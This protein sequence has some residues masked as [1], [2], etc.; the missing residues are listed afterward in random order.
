MLEPDLVVSNKR[1]LL[2]FQ[3]D[4]QEPAVVLL[5]Q[6]A[7]ERQ[8]IIPIRHETHGHPHTRA[9]TA[10]FARTHISRALG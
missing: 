2:S 3:A 9:E 4:R 5:L 7:G 6:D 10:P 1:R 8:S